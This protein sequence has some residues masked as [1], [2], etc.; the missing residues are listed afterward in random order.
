[1]DIRF[2]LIHRSQAQARSKSPGKFCIGEIRPKQKREKNM[3][4]TWAKYVNLQSY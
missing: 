2:H 3:G 1:M 4:E